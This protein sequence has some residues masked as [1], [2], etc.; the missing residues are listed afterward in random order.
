LKKLASTMMVLAF[1]LAAVAPTM[2]RDQ[3]AQGGSIV[4]LPPGFQIEKVV[5]GLTYPTALTWDDQGQ[6]YVAEAGGQFLEEPPPARILRIE[7]G[8]ATE[9]VNL[10]NMGVGASVVG[11]TWHNGAFYFT[12]RD[13]QDRTGAVSR[14]TPDGNRTQLFSGLIDSQSEHQVND[15]KVGPD[16]RMY[17]A[18]GPAGNAAVV[19]IDIAPFVQRSPGLHTT[20]CQ[21]IVLTGQ[22]FMTPDFR[23]EDQGDVALTGAF[24]PFGTETT[25]GQVIPGTNKC[26]GSILVFDP[27]NAEATLR[28]YA[29]GLRNVIGLA[30]NANGEMFAAVNGYDVRGSRPFNDDV[31]PTYRIRE[32]AWYGYPD[33]SAT[34]DPITD[35]RFDLPDVLKAPVVVN[36]QMIGRQQ[37]FVIDHAA[38]GL[39]PPDKSLVFGLHEI[40]S[41]PSML[42]VA[43]AAWGEFAGQLFVAE[44]GDLAPPTSPLREEANPGFRIVRINPAT[45]QAEP[46]VRN[47]KPGP[48][49][50]Q[51]AMGMGLERPFD[52]KF[53]PDG[54]MY[55][56]DYGVARVNLARLAEGQVPYEFPPQ[57]GAIWRVM[58]TDG[59]PPMMPDT[60]IGG[61]AG[62]L[63]ASMATAGALLAAGGYGLLRSSRRRS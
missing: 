59:V 40:G 7:G 1:V 63:A 54:A 22:N 43:P 8:Q 38:S 45:G 42:D 23:T 46:F 44:W 9:V 39:T 50:A 58:R 26:G 28:P 49:S 3:V 21:D 57:T 55:I 32:G 56:V 29:H 36:G 27:D 15:I 34:G 53:G 20:S 16:G 18:A 17:L 13:G 14:V 2:A 41:S 35:P 62:G 11:L 31:E 48:A 5:G 25:P 37:N 51:G 12:H 24:V 33:F 52:V 47:Q 60:G 6:M 61:L 30:W 4:Q 19:G 10:T